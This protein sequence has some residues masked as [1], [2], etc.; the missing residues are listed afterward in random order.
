[1]YQFYSR[2]YDSNLGLWLT[3]DSYRGMKEQ[4]TSLTR[5]TFVENRPITAVDF[6][7]YKTK[8]IIFYDYGVGSHA[9]LWLDNP[10]GEIVL[11]DPD[12]GYRHP[13]EQST[14]Y[15]GTLDTYFGEYA[16]YD[17]FIQAKKDDNSNYKVFTFDT[18]PLEEEK[19]V[20]NIFDIGGG[21]GL[22][23]AR[24][25]SQAING[26]GPFE[27]LGVYSRPGKLGRKLRNLEREIDR[28]EN[29][30]KYECLREQPRLFFPFIIP[31]AIESCSPSIA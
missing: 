9:T 4:P 7:G 24:N 1:M 17:T 14:E 11:Y 29:K 26:V 21:C 3:L 19:I 22:C 18:S 30:E 10:N 23:C 5:Y 6:Y 12:G 2:L 27:D 25:I 8:V 31:P 13:D 20:E 28:E 15:R 16:D